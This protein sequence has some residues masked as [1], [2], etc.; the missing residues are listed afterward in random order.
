MQGAAEELLCGGIHIVG[1]TAR[2]P[3]VI[4]ASSPTESEFLINITFM[5]NFL[6]LVYVSLVCASYTPVG[7]VTETIDDRR[8]SLGSAEA[9]ALGSNLPFADISHWEISDTN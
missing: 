4:R 6:M 3:S 5:A 2:L 8:S 7:F 9:T 1:E